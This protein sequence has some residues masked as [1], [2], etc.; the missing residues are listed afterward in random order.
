MTNKNEE[1][2]LRQDGIQ[3]KNTWH[4]PVNHPSHYTGGKYE[5]ID[6]IEDQLGPDGVIHFCLGNTMK[7][8]CRAGKKDP[9]KE[10]EDLKKAL[11]YLNHAIEVREGLTNG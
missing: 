1:Y 9:L 8:I 3:P 10:L 2:G 11:W 7:Y 4:D 5:V 6:I